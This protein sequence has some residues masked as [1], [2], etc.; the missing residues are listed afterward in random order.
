MELATLTM[1]LA[2]AL[3]EK[4]T[5]RVLGIDDAPF[6][7][8]Q[9]QSVNLSGIICAGTRFEGMLWSEVIRDGLD[10]TDCIIQMVKN[11][12]FHQQLHII[13]IDGVAV[14]GFNII[15]LPAYPNSSTCLV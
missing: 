13:L 9:D 1:R 12:K 5:L 4:K 3:Q 14:A 2:K 8:E 6:N 7:K 11:S 10:A 15:D